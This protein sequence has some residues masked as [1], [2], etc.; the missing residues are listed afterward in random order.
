MN[1]SIADLS[2]QTDQKFSD[3]YFLE[4]YDKLRLCQDHYISERI[5]ESLDIIWDALRLYGPEQLYCSFNG[6]KDAVVIMHLLRAVAT[7]YAAENGLMSRPNFVYYAVKDEFPEV[8]HF[9]K[10]CEDK[11]A[12]NLHHCEAG[13]IQVEKFIRLRIDKSI[14]L[15]QGFERSD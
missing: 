10:D 2:V 12:L 9:I 13:I 3:Q 6:G 5:K 14:S 8:L 4:F 7:R 1:K 11:F 15:C